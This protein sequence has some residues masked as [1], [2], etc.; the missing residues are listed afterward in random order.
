MGPLLQVTFSSMASAP[1]SGASLLA[2]L[3]RARQHNMIL[4]VRGLLL[5][6]DGRFL[7][8]LEGPPT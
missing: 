1:F 5:Y 2:L 7:Q 4:G 3:S 8:V 6:R